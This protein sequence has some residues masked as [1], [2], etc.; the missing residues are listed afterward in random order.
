MGFHE[1]RQDSRPLIPACAGFLWH[2]QLSFFAEN[3]SSSESSCLDAIQYVDYYSYWNQYSLAEAATRS[4]FTRRAL[5]DALAHMQTADQ[6]E[7]HR[8]GYARYPVRGDE[9]NAWE[10]EQVWGDQ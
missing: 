8:L 3:R 6:E 2:S 7:R 5:R 1:N 10:E 9:F 4:A